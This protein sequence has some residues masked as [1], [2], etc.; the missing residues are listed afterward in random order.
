[1]FRIMNTDEQ[2][3]PLDNPID[4]ATTRNRIQLTELEQRHSQAKALG[5]EARIERPQLARKLT[6]RE[7]VDEV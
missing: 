7:R 4:A 1:M 3:P 2:G 6:A 5:G